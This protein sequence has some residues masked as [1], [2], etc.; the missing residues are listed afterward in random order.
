[1]ILSRGESSGDS[2]NLRL[3]LRLV[4]ELLDVLHSLRVDTHGSAV[5]RRVRRDWIDRPLRQR[6]HFASRV[7][8]VKGRQIDVLDHFA[9][10]VFLKKKNFSN[11]FPDFLL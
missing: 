9:D 3:L 5:D 8:A 11:F 7:V 6:H 4:Q 2:G 10:L 1:M